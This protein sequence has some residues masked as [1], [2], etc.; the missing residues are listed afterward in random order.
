MEFSDVIKNRYSCKKFSSEQIGKDKLD[1]ILEAG[2]VAPTAKNL[3][4]QHIY[5]VQSESGLETIDKLTLCRYNA[6]TVLIVAFNKNNVFTYP[7]D[8]RNSGIEEATIVATH[9]MLAAYNEG[10]DSCWINF[11]NPDE[12]A[13]ALNL[14]E[15]EEILM[16]LDLG[17]A[18]KTTTPLPNHNSRK[19]LTETV[20]F[21]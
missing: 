12:L 15:D 20:S 7:G 10:V 4:E 1:A 19:A 11:F 6:P 18:D 2:R 14:P 13:K 3:Q 16:L 5:V 9:L 21:I 8:K 17:V